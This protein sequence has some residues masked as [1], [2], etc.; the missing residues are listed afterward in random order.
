MFGANP[1]T[2]FTVLLA[3]AASGT[4]LAQISPGPLSEAHEKLDSSRGCLECHGAGDRTL[5]QRCLDCHTEIADRID[6]TSGL[7]GRE[8]SE[9]CAS[10]HPEHGGRDFELIEW[11][12]GAPEGFDHRRTGWTLSGRHA[13]T[14][15]RNCHK[16]E[17][18]TERGGS[19]VGRVDPSQTWLGLAS[20][21][22][23]CHE[24]LHAGA[25][26]ETCERC[27]DTRAFSPAPA[28]DHETAAFPLT[29]KHADVTCDRCHRVPGR[30]EVVLSSGRTARLYRP[31]PYGECSSCH[32]DVHR[33]ALGPA[34][35][36]CHVT[37]SFRLVDRKRFDHSGTRYPLRGA[38][39]RL[40]CENC[41]HVERGWGRTPPFQSCSNCHRDVHRGEATL[42]GRTVD[43]ESCHGLEAFR[44]STFTVGMH[45]DSIYPLAGKHADAACSGCHA[46]AA[47]DPEV[48]FRL[49]F[50]RCDGCHADAHA[51]QLSAEVPRADH[52]L[53]SAG[54]DCVNC[55]RV[56]G[57]RPSTFDATRH[58]ELRLELE[59][60]H[61]RIDCAA[62]HGPLDPR[63][64]R[65]KWT[66]SSADAGVR[67]RPLDPACATCHVDPHGGRSMFAGTA[68]SADCVRCHDAKTFRPSRVD[69]DLHASLGYPLEGG[70]RAVPCSACHPALAGAPS[71][72]TMLG[73]AVVP[74]E[75][76]R[77]HERCEDCHKK[78]H[79]GQFEQRL[80]KNSC[81]SCHTV[82]HWRPASGFDHDRDSGFLLGAAHRKV[83]CGRCHVPEPGQDSIRYAA[84]PSHC[85]DCHR[86]NVSAALEA[87]Q[88]SLHALLMY[89]F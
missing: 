83:S 49:P 86:G 18:L 52:A 70:H 51:G 27:H 46:S 28:F 87:P 56:D 88:A 72:S 65:S 34:C 14:R 61:A 71:G 47:P 22:N 60:R 54:G 6:A 84:A 42:A 43:C 25:L 66:L 75:L 31:L 44:P 50:D 78:A 2:L 77:T 30:A 81:A 76:T 85:E 24:D 80:E 63:P 36:D 73:A 11:T 19:G 20:S 40:R 15:C 69:A 55:H 10:C 62:C 3:G 26:G 12:E 32:K 9:D 38:H 21:C 67:L 4:C 79:E 35:S 45:A 16:P 5:D 68:G 13:R 53:S 23:S 58:G 48:R 82:Q 33:G 74:L 29:G 39:E 37:V 7:H 8:A 41:H 57:W 64:A 89:P 17:N 1:R 59:G